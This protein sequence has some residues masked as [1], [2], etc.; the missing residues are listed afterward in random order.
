MIWVD[1]LS[2]AKTRAQVGQNKTGLALNCVAPK[3][4]EGANG[5]DSN[6]NLDK[7]TK[8]FLRVGVSYQ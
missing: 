4:E 2:V 8:S 7:L 6:Y 5:S 1:K 3:S